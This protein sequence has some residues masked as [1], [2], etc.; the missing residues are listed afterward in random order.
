MVAAM[1]EYMTLYVA[2]YQF[3]QTYLCQKDQL[4]TLAG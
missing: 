3:Q 2:E 1:I 4:P